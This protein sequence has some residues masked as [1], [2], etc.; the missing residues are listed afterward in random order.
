MKNNSQ[1]PKELDCKGKD[2]KHGRFIT[3]RFA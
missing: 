3:S 1:L 2:A